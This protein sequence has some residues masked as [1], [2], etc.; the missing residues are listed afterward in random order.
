MK[1]MYE[2]SNIK[3]AAKVT[4]TSEIVAQYMLLAFGSAMLKSIFHQDMQWD[5]ANGVDE[6][7]LMLESQ[8]FFLM[9]RESVGM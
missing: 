6:M 3:N 1:F 9:T 4:A 2:T 5:Y 8:S 7:K